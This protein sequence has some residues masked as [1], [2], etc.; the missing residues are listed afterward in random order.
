MKN[1]LIHQSSEYDCGP[2]CMVNAIRYLYEREEIQ[3]GVLKHIWVMGNDTYCDKGCLGCHGT[4][5]ASMRYMADWLREYG[6]GCG[7]P[8]DAEFLEN[9]D[10]VVGPGTKTWQCLQAGGCAIM[11]CFSGEIPHYVL[12]TAL[13]PEGEVGLFDPYEEE[14]DFKEP[15]RRVI[16]NHPKQMNRAV[17]YDLLNREDTADYA[18]G[19]RD[20][21]ELVLIR[22]TDGQKEKEHA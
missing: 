21:R 12:L 3:P 19:P 4:S 1:A 6:R 7:F 15:G 16:E 9:G 13:L 22:R 8:V 5:R 14:P 2:T 18:M 10:A 20:V 11:R 17:R